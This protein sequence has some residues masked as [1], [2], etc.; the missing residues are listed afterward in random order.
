MLKKIIFPGSAC[1]NSIHG[2]ILKKKTAADLDRLSGDPAQCARTF[3]FPRLVRRA[4]EHDGNLLGHGNDMGCRRSGSTGRDGKIA[5]A[6]SGALSVLHD[7]CRYLRL[8]LATDAIVC[9]GRRA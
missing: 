4:I 6:P 8:A 7:A 2:E 3:D 9:A 1:Y 5:A